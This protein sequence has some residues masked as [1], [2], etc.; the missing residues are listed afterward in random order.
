MYDPDE[1]RPVPF[2]LLLLLLLL[3][4]STS[5]LWAPL[6]VLKICTKLLT[7]DPP[8]LV[9]WADRRGVAAPAPVPIPC[10]EI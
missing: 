6:A 4:P 5:T 1:E 10:A 2:L 9:R 7:R 8:G 3:L